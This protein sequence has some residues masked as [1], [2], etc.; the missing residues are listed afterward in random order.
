[1][2]VLSGSNATISVSLAEDIEQ[3]P[4]SVLLLLYRVGRNPQV[5]LCDSA[6][7]L[8]PKVDWL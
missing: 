3:L 4:S 5:A 6:R 1:M 8:Q 2:S 7:F